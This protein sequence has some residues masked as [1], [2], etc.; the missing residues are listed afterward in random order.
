MTHA[1]WEKPKAGTLVGARPQRVATWLYGAVCCCP[2]SP[3]YMGRGLRTRRFGCGRRSDGPALMSHTAAQQHLPSITT[4]HN[5]SPRSPWS[6]RA[7][8]PILMAIAPASASPT[9]FSKL[10]IPSAH[11]TQH[12]RRAIAWL[13]GQMANS[14]VYRSKATHN[15]LSINA[16]KC[17]HTQES[18]RQSSQL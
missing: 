5:R 4:H 17:L 2:P 16:T 3:R 9:A 7:S 12:T 8:G 14:M 1:T 6:L 13:A 10:F 15:C 18:T 11:H